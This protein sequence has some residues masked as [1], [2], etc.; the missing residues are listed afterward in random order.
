DGQPDQ[1]VPPQTTLSCQPGCT[2]SAYYKDGENCG[3]KNTCPT[4]LDNL[5]L[6][7]NENFGLE[8]NFGAKSASNWKGVSSVTCVNHR[9]IAAPAP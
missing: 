8:V 6:G 1:E 7:C 3:D 9:Y 5:S 4:V 2:L